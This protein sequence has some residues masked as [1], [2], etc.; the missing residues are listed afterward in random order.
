MKQTIV[1]FSTLLTATLAMTNVVYADEQ[2]DKQSI[3]KAYRTMNAA[4]ERKDINQAYANH[5]PEYTLIRQNG[6]LINLEQL[7]QMAQQNFKTIRQINVHHEIQQIQ[8]NG[9]TATVISIAYTSAIISNPKNP[10]VPIPFSSVSQY[11]DIW[12][13]TPGGWKAISTNVLQE[14]VAR[15]QQSS[16]VNRQNFTP[17]QRQLLDQQQMMLWNQRLRDME[18]QRNMFNCMNGL[19]YNCGN[20]IITP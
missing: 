18:M 15:G 2:A 9:Q 7:R 14:N 3:I 11:Q 1:A 12:K 10:Q 20:S 19:G 17:E 4:V 6:K 16:Q 8:I 13:R 5:A